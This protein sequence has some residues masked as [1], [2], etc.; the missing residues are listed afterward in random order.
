MRANILEPPDGHSSYP[1]FVQDV[2][3]EPLIVVNLSRV[4]RAQRTNWAVTQCVR[5]AIV[6]G[7]LPGNLGN[8]DL[9]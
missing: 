4:R 1:L 7:K 9:H 8:K 3:C 5:Y 2:F 6:H